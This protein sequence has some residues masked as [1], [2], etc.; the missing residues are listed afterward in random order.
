M[1]NITVVNRLKKEKTV[2]MIYGIFSGVEYFIG[3][4]DDANCSEENEQMEILEPAIAY[5]RQR[6]TKVC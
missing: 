1:K 5:L 2:E 4:V 6:K 3:C